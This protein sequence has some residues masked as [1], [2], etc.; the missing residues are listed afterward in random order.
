MAFFKLA[1]QA[2]SAQY[3]LADL[4]LERLRQGAENTLKPD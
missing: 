4:L 2:V 3:M 1:T